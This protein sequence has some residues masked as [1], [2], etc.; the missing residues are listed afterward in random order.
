[1]R[2]R[3]QH[4]HTYPRAGRQGKCAWTRASNRTIDQSIA[5]SIFFNQRDLIIMC[6]ASLMLVLLFLHQSQSPWKGKGRQMKQEALVQHADRRQNGARGSQRS[7]PALSSRPHVRDKTRDCGDEDGDGS[8]KAGPEAPRTPLPPV[9]A[10][11]AIR[12]R[13]VAWD[14]PSS[15]K[16]G[17]RMAVETIQHS[18]AS[19]ER[20]G[21]M[22]ALVAGKACAPGGIDSNIAGAGP[23]LTACER[24]ALYLSAVAPSTC[25]Q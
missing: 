15:L 24:A 14:S 20:A 16:S 13:H 23:H 9:P 11:G 19:Q 10:R 22:D 17:E 8:A 3:K 18:R 6:E 21:H 7:S 4:V 25:E 5:R 2:T 12:R 1:M